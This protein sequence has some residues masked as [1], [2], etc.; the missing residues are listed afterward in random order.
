MKT[1]ITFITLMMIF[2]LGS[3]FAQENTRKAKREQVKLE[4]TRQT[5]SLIKSGEFVFTATR[6]LPLGGGSIDLTTNTNYVKFHQNRI[7]SYM[8]FFGIA[9][10]VDYGADGGIKFAG[11]PKEFKMVANSKGKGY[12]ISA[13]VTG[14]MDIYQLSLFVT[15]EGSATLLIISN[16]RNS[17]SYS[18]EIGKLEEAVNEQTTGM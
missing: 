9:Y 1:K 10:N 8:P 2:I 18:G 12:E 11:K 7:E 3:C 6:A 14:K 5:E 16:N 17:I 15:P 13:T 4:R